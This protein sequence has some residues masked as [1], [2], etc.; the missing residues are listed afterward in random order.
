MVMPIELQAIFHRIIFNR[1]I[2]NLQC[3]EVPSLK[4]IDTNSTCPVVKTRAGK[5]II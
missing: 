2:V 4:D 5:K 3:W 1:E